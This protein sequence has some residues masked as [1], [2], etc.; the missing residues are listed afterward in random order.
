M[1]PPLYGLTN[2]S[3]LFTPLQLLI[4]DT[5]TSEIKNIK[6]KIIRDGGEIEYANAIITY[7][8]I[9]LGGR[10]NYWSSFAA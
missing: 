7:L 10:A 3:D 6:E 9:V 2:Y 4:L 8:S 5:F 1:A